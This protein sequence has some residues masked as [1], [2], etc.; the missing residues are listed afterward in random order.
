MELFF[1]RLDI[2]LFEIKFFGPLK[3]IRQLIGLN[4]I[5]LNMKV[6]NKLNYFLK[7]LDII[8]IC[9]KANWWLCV[10]L[11]NTKRF[12]SSIGWPIFK[13]SFKKSFLKFYKTKKIGYDFK[14]NLSGLGLTITSHLKFKFRKFKKDAIFSQNLLLHKK[15]ISFILNYKK[16]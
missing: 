15:Q 3:T 12:L 16:R 9:K 10:M 1:Y 11:K 5:Y 13:F 6:E 7:L 4:F 2:C 14:F 8:T